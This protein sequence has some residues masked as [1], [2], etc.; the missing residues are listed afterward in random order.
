[1]HASAV[2]WITRHRLG[3]RFRRY[4]YT[5]VRMHREATQENACT[6]T[7]ILACMLAM[8]RRSHECLRSAFS[9]R[10]RKFRYI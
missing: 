6:V 4:E 1:M 5:H 8:I 10:G 3:N 9:P 7:C 2:P